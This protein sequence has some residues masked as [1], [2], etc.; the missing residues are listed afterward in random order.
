[1]DTDFFYLALAE[2][3]LE[4][5]VLPKKAHGT[6]IQQN[7]WD[8]F[9]S[10]TKKIFL[11]RAGCAVSKGLI[12]ENLD[13]SKKN[14]VVLERCDCAARRFAAMTVRVINSLLVPWTQQ[15]NAR[16]YWGWANV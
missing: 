4:D 8:D 6:Q 16:R 2:V 3:S 1:M 9:I 11:A 14:L 5:C 7:D 10:D 13:Y 12:N 15:N